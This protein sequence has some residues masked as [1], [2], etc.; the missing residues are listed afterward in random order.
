[1]ILRHWTQKRYIISV[2]SLSTSILLGI[3]GKN[4]LINRNMCDFSFIDSADVLFSTLTTNGTIFYFF[5]YSFAVWR[6]LKTIK[7]L[8]DA[9]NMNKQ[10][11]EVKNKVKEV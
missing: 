4:E 5:H 1:M 9:S 7:C 11:R 8:S 2:V 3:G 10:I 6:K